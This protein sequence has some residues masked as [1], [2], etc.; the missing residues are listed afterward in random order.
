MRKG[1]CGEVVTSRP[2]HIGHDRVAV[3]I[4]TGML[5]QPGVHGAVKKPVVDDIVHM[6]IQVVVV[7][8]RGDR[9]EVAIGAA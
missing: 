8:T 7:P 6:P 9:L 5:D 4:Q 3:D 2:D 1:D